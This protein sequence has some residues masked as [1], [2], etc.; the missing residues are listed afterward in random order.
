MTRFALAALVAALAASSSAT[1]ADLLI[2]D[3]IAMATPSGL[4][5]SFFTGASWAT[6]DTTISDGGFG[7]TF[8]SELG[9]G[10]MIGGTIGAYV[11]DNLR[12]EIEFSYIE[13]KVESIAATD[14]SDEFDPVSRGYNLLANLWYDFDTKNGFTPYVGGGVGYGYNEISDSDITFDGFLYQL[15]AGVK[16]DV[17]DQLELDV[18]YRYR[19]LTDADTELEGNPGY[20][21]KTDAVNHI[22]QAGLTYSF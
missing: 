10:I 14:I 1:A 7:I 12:G 3:P 22:V 5:A 9:V 6:G 19:V 4:Y 8:D 15:G 20:D 13:A 21:V 16:V 2:E 18:G 11:T 17:A